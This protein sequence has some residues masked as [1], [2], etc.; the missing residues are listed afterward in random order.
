MKLNAMIRYQCRSTVKSLCIFYGILYGLMLF[1][2]ILASI[3]GNGTVNSSGAEFSC[4]IYLCFFGSLSFGE[5]FKY[6]LQNGFTRRRIYA[7]TLCTFVLVS[8]FM[9]VF[10]TLM[11]MLLSMS[12]SYSSLFTTLYGAGHSVFMNWLW[13][14]LAYLFFCS[15]SYAAAVLKNRIGKTLF[16]LLLITLGILFFILFPILAL[17]VIPADV[18]QQIAKFFAALLGFG[19]G[20]TVQFWAP[21]L[22]F[23]ILAYLFFNFSYL[24]IRKAELK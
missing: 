17:N 20:V 1:G 4:F 9:S 24:L 2:V 10:D 13:L 23:V 18:L 7:S 19:S 22:T 12:D 5:D 14:L 21:L 6:F 16:V 3:V 8:L 11:S 15:I